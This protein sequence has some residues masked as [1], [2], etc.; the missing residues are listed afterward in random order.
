MT[1]SL[2]IYIYYAS[3]VYLWYILVVVLLLCNIVFLLSL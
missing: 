1:K 2:V 3:D